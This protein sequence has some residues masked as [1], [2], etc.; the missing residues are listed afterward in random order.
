MSPTSEK[1]RT[2]LQLLIASIGSSI[3]ANGNLFAKDV[4]PNTTKPVKI[5]IPA[6]PGGGLDLIART[7]ADRLSQ[8]TG[9]SFISENIGGGGGTIASL[10]TSRAAPDGQTFMV[11]NISTHGTNPAVRNLPYDSMKDFTHIAMVGGSP[12]VLVVGPELSKFNSI[13]A[14]FSDLKKKGRPISYGSAGPGT[15]SHL[16]VEEL[17]VATGIPFLHAPYRGVGPAMVDVMA[18]RV[19]IAFPGLI[20]ALQFIKGNRLKPFAVTSQSRM[21]QLPNIP[22]FTEI[23]M[24]EFSSLQWYG[25][26][27]PAGISV[28]IVNNLNSQINRILKDPLIITKFESETLTLMPMSPQ[29]FTT[30]IDKDLNKWKKLVKER[31]IQV[32]GV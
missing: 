25:I 19:D 23:G 5:I 7:M 18:G 27:G 26:S 31:G 13:E 24:P 21:T 3:S 10:T 6:Q 32:D 22:T 9:T 14:L 29:Q 28:E 2:F 20:A 8:A 4:W 15:S 17:S 30:F 16:L 1:R 12:N 11:V